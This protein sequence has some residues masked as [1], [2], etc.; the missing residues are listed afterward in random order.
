MI[1]EWQPIESAPEWVWIRTKL[2]GEDGENVTRF[3]WADDEREWIDR[4]G[5]TTITHHSFAAPTHW[6]PLRASPESGG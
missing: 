5:R 1:M 6:A 2:E 4:D 3:R